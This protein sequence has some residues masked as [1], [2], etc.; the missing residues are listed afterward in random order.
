MGGGRWEW[1]KENKPWG[2]GEGEEGMMLIRDPRVSVM[3]NFYYFLG[4][5]YHGANN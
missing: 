3:K 2:T 5:N 4:N 1:V